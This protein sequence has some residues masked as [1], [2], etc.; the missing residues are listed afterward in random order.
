MN[1]P[2]YNQITVCAYHRSKVTK[3][4]RNSVSKMF[5][6]SPKLKRSEKKK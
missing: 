4:G 1:L 6:L 3:I 5:S 2:K